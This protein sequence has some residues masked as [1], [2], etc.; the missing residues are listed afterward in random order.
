MA[1]SG[2][3]TVTPSVHTAIR[4]ARSTLSFYQADCLD[5]FASLPSASVSV[6]VTSPPYN[7]GIE[8]RSYDD[9]R[10]RRSTCNGP[11]PGRPRPRACSSLKARCS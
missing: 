11:K 2:T 3:R 7:L 9:S 6:I 8:Y 4:T 1:R 10:P 5:V